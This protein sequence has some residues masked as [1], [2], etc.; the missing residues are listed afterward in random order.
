MNNKNDS[1][2]DHMTGRIGVLLGQLVAERRKT[3]TTLSHYGLIRQTWSALSVGEKI[4]YL[5]IL[6][7]D[8]ARQLNDIV[9]LIAFL[10]DPEV[11]HG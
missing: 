10:S 1:L 5:R 7:H 6:H 2:P 4:G 11:R 9:D 8:T 3:E